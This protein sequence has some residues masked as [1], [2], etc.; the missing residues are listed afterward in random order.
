MGIFQPLFVIFAIMLVGIICTKKKILNAN[1]I[2]GFEAFLFKIA[3]PCYL[4]TSTLHHDFAQ[5][6]YTP[7]IYSYLLSFFAVATVAILCFSK[8]APPTVCIKILASGYVN[9]SIYALPVMTFLLGDPTAG[10]LGN[11]IQVLLIQSLFITILSFIKHKEKSIVEKF[12][13]AIFTP[14]II[15]PLAGLLCNSLQFSPPTILTTVTQNLGNG[16]SSIALFTF[17]LVLGGLKISKEDLSRDLLLTIFLK[18]IFH[19]MI[20]FFIGKYLFSLDKYWFISLLIA[21]SAPTAF[22][23]YLLAKQFSIEQNLIKKTVAVSSLLSLILLIFIAL[24][25]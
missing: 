21:T 13:T 12:L 15:M 7:Y 2:E 14:L 20:A 17:G 25:I 11:L 4:F 16:A 18:N 6:L 1:Q 24:L 9:T 5:L 23:I 3:M 10:I 19:P 22:V 8:E